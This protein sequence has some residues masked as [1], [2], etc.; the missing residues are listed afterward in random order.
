MSPKKKHNSLAD[1]INKPISEMSKYEKDN[2]IMSEKLQA[3]MEKLYY[4]EGYTLGKDALFSVLEAK[5]SDAEKKG[6]KMQIPTRIQLQHW[7]NKQ[8]LQQRFRGTIQTPFLKS[9][10]Q[11]S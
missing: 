3:L 5:Q 10:G 7:L 2:I 6:K 8:E 4:E 1:A 9:L 11:L